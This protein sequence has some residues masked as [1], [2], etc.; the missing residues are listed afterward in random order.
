MPPEIESSID[1]QMQAAAQPPPAAAQAPGTP[2]PAQAADPVAQSIDEEINHEKYGSLGQ[3]AKTF[4][5]SA[6]EAATFGLSTGIERVFGVSPE[7]IRGRREENPLTHVAGQATGLGLTALLPGA[8]EA[9]I[10]KAAL[11]AERAVVGTEALID[12]ARINPFS[13][14][15]VMTGLG[16]AAA[17]TLGPAGEEISASI[18]RNGIKGAAETALFQAGDEVSKMISEDPGQSIQSAA[19]NIGLSGLLGATAGAAVGAV[20][21]LWKA[22]SESKAGQIITGFKNRAQ[23]YLAPEEAA[24]RVAAKEAASIPPKEAGQYFDP[25]QKRWVD[26]IPVEPPKSET[27]TVLDPI[28]GAPPKTTVEPPVAPKDSGPTKEEQ[29]G[30]RLF[31]VLMKNGVLGKVSA[32]SIAATAG[33]VL[34]HATG[35]GGFMGAIIAD[36]ALTPFLESVLPSLVKPILRMEASGEA[37]KAAATYGMS[38]V[39]GAQLTAKAADA[40]FDNAKEVLPSHLIASNKDIDKLDERVKDLGLKPAELIDAGGAVGHYLPQHSVAL[41]QTLSG[42]VNYLNSQRPSVFKASPLDKEIPPTAAQKSAYD[43]T[44]KIAQQPLTVMQHIKDGVLTSKDVQDFGALYPDLYKSMR[45]KMY[46]SMV[47]HVAAGGTVPYSTRMGVSLFL[48]NPVDSTLTPEAIQAAQATFLASGGQQQGAQKGGDKK[49]LSKMAS[50]T[51]TPAQ[52][53]E[54][55]K[56]E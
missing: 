3:Q 27:A 38:V 9:A 33:G 42:A 6:G 25:M 26:K 28:K 8:G 18:L 4:A 29:A 17:K 45:S 37:L 30:S 19:T 53:R 52:A 41:G 48:G 50:M 43:R 11:G 21:P 23:E 5:E 12:A 55:S 39:R 10:G 22:A 7:D 15:S 36:H 20:S 1:A 44:L 14:H 54:Q 47:A 2:A 35:V 24:A 46:G 32:K 31:D 13:A 16:E 56:A 49:P 51:Q 40:V 34:G